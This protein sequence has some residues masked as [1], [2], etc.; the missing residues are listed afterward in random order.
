ML[1]VEMRGRFDRRVFAV[2]RNE[3][4]SLSLNCV[5]GPF[6]PFWTIS[7]SDENLTFYEGW[8]NHVSWGSGKGIA[9]SL[10]P[11]KEPFGF[12]PS[13]ARPVLALLNGI[14]PPYFARQAGLS[15]VRM[16]LARTMDRMDTRSQVVVESLYDSALGHRTWSDVRRSLV[17]SLNRLTLNFS[18]EVA[19][20]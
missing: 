2:S 19:C 7:S 1:A 18:R 17:S 13:E 11:L 12:P 8:G 10:A 5:T 6:P 14:A 15:L 4:C 20:H 16:P 3:N 9:E